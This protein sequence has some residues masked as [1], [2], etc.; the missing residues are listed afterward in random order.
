MM[1][2]MV[3]AVVLRQASDDR[4]LS[5]SIEAAVLRLA[6]EAGAAVV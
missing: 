4:A 3:G 1:A 2:A 6:A 5:D